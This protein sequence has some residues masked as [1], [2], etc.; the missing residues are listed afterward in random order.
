MASEFARSRCAR[1][2]GSRPAQTT[3]YRLVQQHAQTFFTQTE[4]TTEVGLPK[5]DQG[6]F[7]AYFEC[8]IPAHPFLR[9]HCAE[10]GLN[11]LLA[12]SCKR[13]GFCPSSAAPRMAQ[14]TAYLVEQGSPRVPA[15]PVG[16]VA[17]DP[18][19]VAARGATAA[20]DTGA[21]GR[22][23]CLGASFSVHRFSAICILAVQ[24]VRN[25]DLMLCT[26]HGTAF[27]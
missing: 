3:L 13:R 23:S 4:E 20:G 15:A 7:D 19:E 8:G 6:A 14:I 1:L 26:N 9:P 18:H 2:L 25:A 27:A 22:A 5:F 10:Y 16:A 11:K 24:F 21:A 17:A 12:F